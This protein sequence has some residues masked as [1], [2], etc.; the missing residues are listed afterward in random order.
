MD[1]A[2][3]WSVDL[4]VLPESAPLAEERRLLIDGSL[5]GLVSRNRGLLAIQIATEGPV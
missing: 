1:H 4:L 2:T 5:A 3:P